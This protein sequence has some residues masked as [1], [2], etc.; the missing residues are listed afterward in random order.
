MAETKAITAKPTLPAAQRAEDE[1]LGVLAQLDVDVGH[2]IAAHE[3]PHVPTDAVLFIDDAESDPGKS[4]IQIAQNQVDRGAC[5][6]DVA[7][8]GAIRL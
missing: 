4:P 2:G 3:D 6:L 7:R 8:P 5:R 1:K